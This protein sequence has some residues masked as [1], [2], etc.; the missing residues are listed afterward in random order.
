M[1][2]GCF[3]VTHGSDTHHYDRHYWIQYALAQPFSR[4][5]SK[6]L[7]KGSK[8]RTGHANTK[9]AWGSCGT[10]LL[11]SLSK[12]SLQCKHYRS[13]GS[14][15]SSAVVENMI[16]T[17]IPADH[18]ATQRVSISMTSWPKVYHRGCG[19]SL[20][21]ACEHLEDV[22]DFRPGVVEY[23]PQP[24][25]RCSQSCLEQRQEYTRPSKV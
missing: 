19:G 8:I 16:P 2:L 4:R 20:L 9:I 11:R 25:A 21:V 5:S 24:L 22:S 17:D 15:A 10:L 18:P 1:E 6:N 3:L 12:P 14:G 7:R 13:P 23:P